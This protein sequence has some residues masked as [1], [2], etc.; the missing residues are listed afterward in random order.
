MYTV[1][2]TS[3]REYSVASWEDRREPVN[4]YSIV[5]NRCS[6]PASFRSRNCK[7][8]RLV[9]AF[10]ELESGAWAFEFVGTEIQPQHLA[11]LEVA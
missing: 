1:R 7:H 3:K 4:V 6:C 2:Q 8:L 11:I 9:S 5:N 10:Q